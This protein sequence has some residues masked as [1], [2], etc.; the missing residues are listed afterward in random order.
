LTHRGLERIAHAGPDYAR[1]NFVRGWNE[2][3]GQRLASWL[4]QAPVGAE[5]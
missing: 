2:F 3:I 1:N 5:H 4:Q